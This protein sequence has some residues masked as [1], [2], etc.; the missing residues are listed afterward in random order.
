MN[1]R[2]WIEISES[3][4]VH[5]IH[6]LRR[7]LSPGARF[8]AVV[9]GNAYGHGLKQVVDIATRHGVDA[10]AVD[11]IDDALLIHQWTP[12]ALILVL[13]YTMQDR[14]IDAITKE[15]HLTVY[16]KETIEILEQKA[17]MVSK[18]ALIHLKIE[19]G[20]HRQGVLLEHLKDVLD[21]IRVREH[22]DLVGMSTHFANVEEADDASYANSQFERFLQA[23]QQIVA[24]GF[25]PLYIHTACSAALILYPDTH[26]TLVR[27]GIGLYGLWSS[28]KTQQFIRKQHIDFDLRPVM[29]W[30]TRIAQIKSVTRG[31]PIGYNLTEIVK[32][33]SH[34]AILP[35]GYWDGYDRKLSSKGEVLIGGHRCRVLGRI[36]MN[37]MMV[38]VSAIPQLQIE[39][40][41]VLLG[42][43]GRHEITAEDLAEKIDTINYEVVTRLQPKLPRI[44]VP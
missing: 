1:E 30:K 3:A 34:I 18:K 17:K 36:C 29:T 42:R 41:V 19:T 32:Q 37:M 25:Q 40:E 8:C 27:P 14:F 38:D 6:Q 44:I 22:I 15:I 4:L 28:K 2:T 11:H 9:K 20:T 10:F 43:Q 12:H 7:L 31:A 35:V 21:V 23:K 13:G 16:D 39:Q 26:Q 33:N 24:Q 5:N